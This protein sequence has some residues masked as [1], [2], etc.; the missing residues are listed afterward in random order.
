MRA[1]ESGRALLRWLSGRAIEAGD[2]PE[3]AGIPPHRREL[4]AK[5]ARQSADTWLE[6][7]LR[8]E[9]TVP[10]SEIQ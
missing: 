9:A 8:V 4:V 2:L 6:F 7:A 5:I 1:K 3:L 10:Q